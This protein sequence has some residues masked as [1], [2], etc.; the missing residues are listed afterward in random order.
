MDFDSNIIPFYKFKPVDPILQRGD[1][2]RFVDVGDDSEHID[3]LTGIV[4]DITQRYTDESDAPGQA[5]QFVVAVPE[6]DESWELVTIHLDQ[7]H[8]ILGADAKELRGWEV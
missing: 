1:L 8:R 3:G 6:S 4:T 5:A 2:V 7:V